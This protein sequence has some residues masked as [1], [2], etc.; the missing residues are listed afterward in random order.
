MAIGLAIGVALPI[1]EIWTIER[2]LHLYEPGLMS[3]SRRPL[4]AWFRTAPDERM[5]FYRVMEYNATTG[6]AVL[7]VAMTIGLATH[8][9]GS[10][11][12]RTELHEDYRDHAG[13]VVQDGCA[14]QQ[15]ANGQPLPPRSS[16][17]LSKL[18]VYPR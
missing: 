3:M 13:G 9:I 7:G 10:R 17:D 12:R 1:W 16:I 5:R 14:E 8:W 11:P 2:T 15:P 4:W 6:A 18:P